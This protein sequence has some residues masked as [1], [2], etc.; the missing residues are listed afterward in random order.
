MKKHLILLLSD[1]NQ[2]SN[3]TRLFADGIIGYY[4]C[5]IKLK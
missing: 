1:K 5:P 2:E 3:F 4:C